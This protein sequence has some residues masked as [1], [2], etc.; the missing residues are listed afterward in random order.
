MDKVMERCCFSMET[1]IQI[2]E[3]DCHQAPVWSQI[4]ALR[5]QSTTHT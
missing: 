5:V 4:D 3:N 2:Q 1:N